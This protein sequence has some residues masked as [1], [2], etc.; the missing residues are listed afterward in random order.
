MRSI[1][2]GKTILAALKQNAGLQSIVNDNIFPL[3]KDRR[4][5]LGSLRKDISFGDKGI[6]CRWYF[7]SFR[8]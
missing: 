8:G 5:M 7:S 2:I 3:V 4:I 1:R 6:S